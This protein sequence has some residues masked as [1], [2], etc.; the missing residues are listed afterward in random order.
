[1]SAR[2]DEMQNL[3]INA[4]RDEIESRETELNRNFNKPDR[5]T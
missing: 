1:M 2:R 4:R 5:L 3:Y